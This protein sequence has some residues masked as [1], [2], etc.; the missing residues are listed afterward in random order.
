LDDPEVKL[1]SVFG[2]N[3]SKKKTD[4]QSLDSELDSEVST[5]QPAAELID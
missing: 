5:E 4:K 1:A 3:F 2:D